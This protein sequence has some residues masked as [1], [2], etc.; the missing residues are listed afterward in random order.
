MRI[1]RKD[2]E[3]ESQNALGETEWYHTYLR[4]LF[5][6]VQTEHPN[7]PWK[8][9]TSTYSQSMQQ[10]SRLQGLVPTSLVFGVA[11]GMTIHPV[12]IPKQR[13]RMEAVHEAWTQMKKL[14]GDLVS[15]ELP[16]VAYRELWTTKWK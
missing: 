4:S 1:M 8:S 10:Q 2:A 7:N 12:K 13:V 6:R 3:V 9:H 14:M 16:P 5:E 11:P 15:I